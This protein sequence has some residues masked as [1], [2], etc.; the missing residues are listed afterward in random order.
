MEE[1]QV[2][3]SDTERPSSSTTSLQ[4]NNQTA[5]PIDASQNASGLEISQAISPQV[6]PEIEIDPIPETEKEEQLEQEDESK[7]WIAQEHAFLKKQKVRLKSLQAR[8]LNPAQAP[9]SYTTLSTKEK[10]LHDAVRNFEAQYREL[11]SQRKK[12]ALRIENEFGIQV[13]GLIFLA[14]NP[15]FLIEI[16][17]HFDTSYVTAVQRTLDILGSSTLRC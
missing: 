8:L 11:F 4:A 12:L 10:L 15:K 14:R 3:V 17:V 7:P 1:P 6:E 16:C 2:V 9:I 13:E 5:S